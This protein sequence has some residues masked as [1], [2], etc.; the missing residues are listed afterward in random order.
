[1]YLFLFL[2]QSLAHSPPHDFQT[3]GILRQCCC[4]LGVDGH[5]SDGRCYFALL[6]SH[7]RSQIFAGWI[8]GSSRSWRGGRSMTSCRLSGEPGLLQGRTRSLAWFHRDCR[9]P[10]VNTRVCGFKCR[11]GSGIG[12]GTTK[13]VAC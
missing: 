7:V 4:Y 8:R 13:T 5:R 3:L 6:S 10:L 1:M 9:Q 2:S 11:I 12:T